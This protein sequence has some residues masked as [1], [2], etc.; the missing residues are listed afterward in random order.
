MPAGL[1]VVYREADGAGRA[2]VDARKD[3]GGGFAGER[4]G[5][6]AEL[7]FRDAAHFEILAGAAVFDAVAAK[8]AAQV[9]L[10]LVD[11]VPL[12]AVFALIPANATAVRTCA[13]AVATRD[14][15]DV[16]S[17]FVLILSFGV[18]SFSSALRAL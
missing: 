4:L 16:S 6:D 1:S 15:A 11:A 2:G 17:H 8:D 5:Y 7:L 13:V 14:L 9:F 10:D 3:L 12:A 18:N